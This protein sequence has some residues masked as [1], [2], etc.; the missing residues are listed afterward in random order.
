ML[1]V[2]PFLGVFDQPGEEVL[3][4]AEDVIGRSSRQEDCGIWVDNADRDRMVA[5][6]KE[7]GRVESLEALFRAKDGRVI[8]GLMSARVL[9]LDDQPCVISITRDI[10]P[11]KRAEEERR[12]MALK[13]HQNSTC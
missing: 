13:L 8:T 7:E 11:L 4:A 6:L 12:Q 3:V 2:E 9:E 5:Q 10:T 1:E